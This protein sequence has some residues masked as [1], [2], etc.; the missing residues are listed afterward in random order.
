MEKTALELEELRE[1]KKFND[2]EYQ[3]GLQ[4]LDY[5]NLQ[6]KITADES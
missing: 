3:K 1:K 2:L 5:G 6:N 4:D